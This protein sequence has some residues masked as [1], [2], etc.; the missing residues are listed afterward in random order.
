MLSRALKSIVTIAKG[1]LTSA[2]NSPTTPETS[3]ARNMPGHSEQEVPAS[4]VGNEKK[5]TRDEVS[6]STYVG[7]LQVER[8]SL[9]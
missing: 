3:N 8:E 1:D 9:Y 4:S 6:P 5:R 2:T 7:T